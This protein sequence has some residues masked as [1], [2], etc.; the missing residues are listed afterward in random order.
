MQEG[1]WLNPLKLAQFITLLGL[2]HRL[3]AHC[4]LHDLRHLCLHDEYLLQCRWWWQVA[5]V[6]VIVGVGI[7]VMVP[8]VGHLKRRG[9]HE[10]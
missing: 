8:C 3:V 4:L 10:I 2:W 1:G 6:V 5:L 7:D 9:V